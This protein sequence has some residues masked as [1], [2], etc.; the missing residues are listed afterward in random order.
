MYPVGG[1]GLPN[2]GKRRR[3]RRRAVKKG[4]GGGS[5]RPGASVRTG[6]LSVRQ[7]AVQNTVLPSGPHPNGLLEEY[8]FQA[9][10]I[11]N[12]NVYAALFDQYRIKAVSLTFLPTTQ[13]ADTVNQGGTFASSVDLDGD[14]GITTFN[15]LLECANTKTSPWSTAGGMT[16]FKKVYLRP[17]AN[18][19]IITSINPATGQPASFTSQLANPNKWI[20]MTDKGQTVHYGLNV[21]WNFGNNTLNADQDVQI[22]KTYY[23]QFRKVR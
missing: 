20:D 2:R 16:P 17:R 11:P 21:G 7:K 12:F 15:Q 22:I 9:A 5:M 3:R 1:R 19:A 4:P 6:F 8:I 18:N 23:I 10:D 13:T 14:L